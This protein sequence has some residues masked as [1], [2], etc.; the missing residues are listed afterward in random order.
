MKAQDFIC[1]ETGVTINAIQVRDWENS[2]RRVLR[3]SNGR[4]ARSVNSRGDR[5]LVILVN[6][7]Q[8]SVEL[9][10]NDWV[11]RHPEE[12]DALI[13]YSSSAAFE[14]FFVPVEPQ[15]VMWSAP[16]STR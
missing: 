1:V 11:W 6:N 5:C 9:N 13:F 15:I 4:I 3:W 7:I 16:Y 8:N 2:A 12:S 14:N 10:L